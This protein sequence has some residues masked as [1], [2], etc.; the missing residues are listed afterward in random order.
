MWSHLEVACRNMH[1]TWHQPDARHFR[2]ISAHL[3]T[4]SSR[5]LD[6]LLSVNNQDKDNNPNLKL[7]RWIPRR[8]GPNITFV[9]VVRRLVSPN[10]VLPFACSWD[11]KSNHWP[12]SSWLQQS[13]CHSLRET[14]AVLDYK[15]FAICTY[16]SCSLCLRWC[17]ESTRRLFQKK[18]T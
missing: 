18:L 14:A 7:P 15:R 16:S 1:S 4:R 2:A 6:S 12:F 13:L 17:V 3:L 10:V 9:L 8:C 5:Y 11:A